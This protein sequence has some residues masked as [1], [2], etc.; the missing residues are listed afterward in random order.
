MLLGHVFCTATG[1]MI[2]MDAHPDLIDFIS[3]MDEVKQILQ[4]QHTGVR[5]VVREH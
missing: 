3:L 4:D 1:K 2:C 5:A